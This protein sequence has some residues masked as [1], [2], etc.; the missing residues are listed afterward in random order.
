MKSMM[1]EKRP[2]DN[3]KL[4]ADSPQEEEFALGNIHP[5]CYYYFWYFPN[6]TRTLF[7]QYIRFEGVGEEVKEVWKRE[8]LRMVKKSIFHLGKP[9]FTSK[10]PPHT[11]R[12]KILKEL[13]PDAK[14]VYIYRNPVT[15]FESTKKLIQ[16]TIPPL[17]FQ[18]ISEAQIEAD[19]FYIYKALIEQYEKDKA[20]LS[21]SDL[22]EVRYE[23]LEKSPMEVMKRI[24]DELHL[25]GW[26]EAEPNIRTYVAGQKKYQKNKYNISKSKVDEILSHWQF[27]MDLYQYDLPE[28]LEVV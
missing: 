26:T 7:D 21:P 23:N 16:S 18:H 4:T 25:S 24:Y 17:Q 19:I 12:I 10:N 14:F 9:R 28:D 1:P 13:F 5:Y 8:Y 27:A 11:G 3:V 20:L 15:V 22:T 6:E 2:S